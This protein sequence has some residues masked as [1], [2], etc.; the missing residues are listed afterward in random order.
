MAASMLDRLVPVLILLAAGALG[1]WLAAGGGEAPDPAL[2]PPGPEAPAPV[3]EPRPEPGAPPPERVVRPP[4]PAPPTPPP[5]G[6]AP[7][8]SLTPEEIRALPRGELIVRVVNA[9]GDVRPAS[10]VKVRVERK[11]QADWVTRLPERDPERAI[12][13]F[14][15][16]L[17]GDFEVTI[18]GEEVAETR[19]RVRVSAGAGSE[20]AIPVEDGAWASYVIE[21]QGEGGV[22]D[23]T[24]RV[25]DAAGTPVEAWFEGTGQHL[26]TARKARSARLG[27]EGRVYGLKPG[28]YV[29]EAAI[30]DGD[31]TREAFVAEVGRPAQVTLRAR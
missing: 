15:D 16:L 22:A 19:R 11:G 25:L 24:L 14:R 18:L 1:W 2:P 27:A 4:E 10:G 28:R 7:A 20:V 12:F 13:H 17:A 30:Q 3:P 5:E 23:A 29:L 9:Q 8:R 31:T 26:R 21:R 6:E